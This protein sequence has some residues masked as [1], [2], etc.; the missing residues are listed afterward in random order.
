VLQYKRTGV[1][2]VDAERLVQLHGGQFAK[3]IDGPGGRIMTLFW[4]FCSF[5]EG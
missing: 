2:R 1:S 4:G 5:L 3:Q